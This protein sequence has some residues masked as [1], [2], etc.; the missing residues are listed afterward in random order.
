MDYQIFSGGLNG[1][2][3]IWKIPENYNTIDPYDTYE[4]NLFVGNLKGHT[5]AIWSFVAIPSSDESSVAAATLSN[6]EDEIDAAKLN[7]DPIDDQQIKLIC[8]A[9]SDGTIKIWNIEQKTCIKTITCD[10]NLGRPTC[11][12]ALPLNVTLDSTGSNLEAT[13]TI[14]KQTIKSTTSLSQYL[15]VSYTKGSIQIYDLNSSNYSQAVLTFESSNKIKNQ[16]NAIVVHPTL[17]VIV[18]A[19]QDRNLRFWDYTTGMLLTVAYCLDFC[20]L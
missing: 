7:V 17:T 2:I 9:S 6:E 11:L 12:S 5:D 20:N 16:I 19:H 18:S 15:A 10:E 1:E 3:L 13:S 8:S 14:N 4:P